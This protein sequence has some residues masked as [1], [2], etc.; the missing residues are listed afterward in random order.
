MKTFRVAN[1]HCASALWN[2][3]DAHPENG[4]LQYLAQEFQASLMDACSLHQTGIECF[5]FA[6]GSQG[7]LVIK[8]DA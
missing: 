5:H 6:L 4:A 1:A 8:G 3:L 2:E 7:E